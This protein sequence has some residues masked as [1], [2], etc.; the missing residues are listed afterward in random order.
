M[1]RS[2]YEGINFTNIKAPILDAPT[3]DE[4]HASVDVQGYDSLVFIVGVGISGDSLSGSVMLEFEMED[5]PDDSV[6][7]DAVDG[8]VQGS[9]AGATS[10]GTFAVVDDAAEDDTVYAGGYIGPERY[11]R[12]VTNATGTHT[13]GTELSIAAIQGHAH[14][15]PVNAA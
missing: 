13:N 1:L 9:I 11:A 8:D 10:T 4:D 15:S 3:I 14:V 12:V 5:S 7:T 2:L 6:W